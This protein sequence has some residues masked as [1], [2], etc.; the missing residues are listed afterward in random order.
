MRVIKHGCPGPWG[1]EIWSS[2]ASWFPLVSREGCFICG[3]WNATGKLPQFNTERNQRAGPPFHRWMNKN[4]SCKSAL[5]FI[6]N[7][8]LQL[9]NQIC[10]VASLIE[11]DPSGALRPLPPLSYPWGSHAVPVGCVQ[12]RVPEYQILQHSSDNQK[13]WPEWHSNT[14]EMPSLHPNLGFDSQRIKVN[15]CLGIKSERTVN[16]FSLSVLRH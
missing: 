5:M 12:P 2:S 15:M 8:C 9:G 13:T 4:Q 3:P 6:C 16:S 1:G 11:D 10:F 14:P 7:S